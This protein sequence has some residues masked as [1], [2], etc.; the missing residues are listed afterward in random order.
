MGVSL[1]G[2]PL[3]GRLPQVLWRGDLDQ[4]VPVAL[5]YLRGQRVLV[6]QECPSC[7]RHLGPAHRSDRRWFL[8]AGDALTVGRPQFFVGMDDCHASRLARSLSR[9]SACTFNRGQPPASLLI[10]RFVLEGRASS[11]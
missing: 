9:T 11:L 7:F 6:A 5:G 8:H 3:G 4:P 1:L 10:T 2:G